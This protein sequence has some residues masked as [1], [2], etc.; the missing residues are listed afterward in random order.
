[1]SASAHSMLLSSTG[2][3]PASWAC[4][5][6]RHRAQR[7]H[8]SVCT[9]EQVSGSTALHCKTTCHGTPFRRLPQLAPALRPCGACTCACHLPAVGSS[10]RARWGRTQSAPAPKAPARSPTPL[11]APPPAARLY[12][13][14]C[15]R[16]EQGW[17]EPQARARPA[18]CP[19]RL[20]PPRARRA[21]IVC[22]PA[23]P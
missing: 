4:V 1:M 14:C 5:A 23:P 16:Q 2:S 21:H 18:R 9:R 6:C 11:H 20:R 12:C 22:A 15:C 10:A 8:H 3:L 7:I 17:Q 13:C 19:G